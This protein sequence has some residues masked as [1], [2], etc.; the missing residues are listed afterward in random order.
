MCTLQPTFLA[1]HT[2]SHIHPLRPF[3]LQLPA[4]AS[5][6]KL[7]QHIPPQGPH[8][9]GLRLHRCN[10]PQVFVGLGPSAA[11][12]CF[13]ICPQPA[14]VL[15]L[16]ISFSPFSSVHRLGQQRPLPFACS[17]CTCHAGWANYALCLVTSQAGP[18]VQFARLFSCIHRTGWACSALCLVTGRQLPIS[19]LEKVFR[20]A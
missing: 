5:V 14:Q 6:F 12:A 11:A 9:S 18:T 17:F 8:L 7:A 19:A 15:P 3:L 20:S 16:G 10:S 2:L 13:S 1:Q 4:P